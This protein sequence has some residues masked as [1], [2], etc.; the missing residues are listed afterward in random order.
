MS[1]KSKL[2][3]SVYIFFIIARVSG[4]YNTHH[5]MCSGQQR[6]CSVDRV[7]NVTFPPP[8]LILSAARAHNL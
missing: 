8:R 1:F 4:Q 7:E 3:G 2:Q 5:G 6:L